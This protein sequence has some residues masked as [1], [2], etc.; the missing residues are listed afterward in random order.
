MVLVSDHLM[1]PDYILYYVSPSLQPSLLAA[2]FCRQCL[3][4]GTKAPGA[5]KFSWAPLPDFTHAQQPP[6][7]THTSP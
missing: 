1:G 7:N 4:K 2:I 5:K 6:H 3:T